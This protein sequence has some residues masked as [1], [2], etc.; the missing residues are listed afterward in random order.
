MSQP[1]VMM[2]E[3]LRQLARLQSLQVMPPLAK[4]LEIATVK[5]LLRDLRPTVS[6]AQTAAVQSRGSNQ[7]RLDSILV[8]AKISL[9]NKTLVGMETFVR[10]FHPHKVWCRRPPCCETPRNAPS[11]RSPITH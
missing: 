2:V 1:G 10:V 8:S 5:G 7:K 6:Q 11:P 4:P 3:P 9:R